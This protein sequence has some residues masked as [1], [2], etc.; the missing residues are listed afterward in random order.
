M[1]FSSRATAVRS[2]LVLC[3]EEQPKIALSQCIQV[4]TKWDDLVTYLCNHLIDVDEFR[5]HIPKSFMNELVDANIQNMPQVRSINCYCDTD[6]AGQVNVDH[7]VVPSKGAEK[8]EFYPT[9]DFELQLEND[10]NAA[11]LDQSG[12]IN[13]SAVHNIIQSKRKRLREKS[14]KD[15][16]N[17]LIEAKRFASTGARSTPRAVML[18]R[19]EMIR[20]M[21]LEYNKKYKPVNNSDDTRPKPS[22]IIQVS[23]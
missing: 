11:V 23:D 15:S 8:F 3:E 2:I 18:L 19:L 9:R 14:M 5:L 21:I 7:L 12:S 22:P 1:T 17:G 13:V 10:E 20:S 6:D 4:F 16:D